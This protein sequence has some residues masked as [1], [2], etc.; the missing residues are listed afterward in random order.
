MTDMHSST[1]FLKLKSRW[2]KRHKQ[3]QKQLLTQHKKVV[4]WVDHTSKHIA[5]G[6]MTGLLMLAHPVN[7]TI[8]SHQFVPPSPQEDPQAHT[9]EELVRRLADLLPEKVQELGIDQ[10]ISIAHTLSTFFSLPVSPTVE[11]RRLNRA[12][13]IIGA[14]QHLARHPGDTIETHFATPSESV[15]VSSGMAPGRGAWGHFATSRESMTQQD[16]DREKYYI[17]VPTFLSPGWEENPQELYRLF[18]YRKMLVVNP[19]NGKVIIVVIGDAGPAPWTGK[20][21]GGSP[22]VMAHL[23]RVDGGARGPVLYFFVDDPSDS[24]PLGPI[25]L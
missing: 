13:G 7:A 20:H 12:Y 17:A 25:E 6:S 23:E 19:E 3:I 14:E 15:H 24:I 22:E 9:K 21:L 8:I 4:K 11:Q 18:R 2:I 1:H 5:V 16:S 10:E